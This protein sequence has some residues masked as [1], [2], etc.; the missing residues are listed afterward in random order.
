LTLYRVQTETPQL[1]AANAETQFAVNRSLGPLTLVGFDLASDTVYPGGRVDLTL[2]WRAN[3]LPRDL[4]ATHLGERP[5]EAHE[6]GLGNLG[7]YIAE[8]Q[9]DPTDAIVETYS[10]VVP[11]TTP[12]GEYPLAISLQSRW[13]LRP[14]PAS[15][16]RDEVDP[17]AETLILA[18]IKVLDKP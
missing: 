7:R 5:L 15:S 3:N 14:S 18:K 6:L 13:P 8:V 4:I 10:V 11:S 16:P 2:Y 9:P 1:T 12:V 17:L